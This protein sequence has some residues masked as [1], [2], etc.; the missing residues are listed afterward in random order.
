M[1]QAFARQILGPPPPLDVT[2]LPYENVAMIR[3]DRVH[4]SLSGNKW[5]K[6]LPV[7]RSIATCPV[8]PQVFSFGGFWSNHLHALAFA[9]DQLGFS[10]TGFIRGHPDQAWSDTLRD[11]VG[12]GMTPI[13][14]SREDY[15]RRHDPDWCLARARASLE[16][17]GVAPREQTIR[18][19]PEGGSDESALSGLALWAEQIEGISPGAGP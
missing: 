13:F 2:P 14:L 8:P 10:L 12:W 19:I 18:I 5:Y 9:S 17:L 15:R 7:L 1:K 4:P 6:L 11:A 16:V 3:G